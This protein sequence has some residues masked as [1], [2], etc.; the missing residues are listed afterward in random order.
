MKKLL[1]PPI[2]DYGIIGDCHTAVLISKNGSMDWYCPGKFDAPAVFCRLLDIKKGGCFRIAPA[3]NFSAKRKYHDNTNVLET[4]FTVGKAKVKVIDFMPIH[5]RTVNRRG[6]DVGTSRRILRLVEGLTGKMQLEI[7]F[8][9]T[10]DYAQGQTLAEIKPNFCATA[11]KN[12]KR[13]SLSSPGLNLNFKKTEQNEF[14]SQFMINA[15]D[16]QWFVV[17][18]TDKPNHILKSLS[19]AQCEKQLLETE[20]YWKKWAEQCAYRGPYRNEVVRSALTL[21]LLT[22][23]PTGAILAAPTTSL[24]EKIGGV[25]NWDYRFSWI[26]DSA[27]ILYALMNIGYWQEAADF[28]EWLQETH[29]RDSKTDLQ[30]LYGV[31]GERELSEKILNHLQG[32]K[33]SR[34]VRVGNAA[35]SQLQLDIYGE[36]LTAAYLYFISGIGKKGKKDK[37]ERLIERDWPLLRSLVERAD[38]R[39]QE[40]DNGIWEV[41]GKLKPFLY[42]KLMCWAA[43]DRGIRLAK[44]YS[45][46]APIAKWE[47]S[48][49]EIRKTIL[50]KGFNEKIG[51]FTQSF[52]SDS[53]D[54]SCLLIPRTGLLPATD[55]RM[56]STIKAIKSKLTK[57]GLVYRYLSPDGLPGNEGMF[58]ACTFWL[59]DAL[60]L[61][62]SID[63]AHNLFEKA[64]KYANDL[65]LFSEEIDAK[66][67]AILGNFPQGF[68]HMAQINAA[69]NLAKA[70][71]HGAEESP[72]TEA[73]RARK[74]GPAASEGY[75]RKTNKKFSKN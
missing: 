4:V 42:S 11:R 66:E 64:S 14:S 17:N 67:S 10:F 7:F 75:Y 56:K 15:G 65:G 55:S 68:T 32:Y 63:E 19:S 6:Y 48:C 57:K 74:A 28:F 70:T 3:K 18:E 71:K 37:K 31:N 58:L 26:R 51:S 43:F 20:D 13:I 9:P 62:G 54:A 44:E 22:H 8:H 27:L 53:L 29:H 30:V 25:R 39:W 40:P 59:V 49:E 46:E 38:S 2:E 73:E 21:K 61:S 24:P 23:E 34:P 60:A 69:I 35:A 1:Y 33:N 47:K 12:K 36:A 16:R 72:E 50:K 52:G 41:R 45:L 5:R